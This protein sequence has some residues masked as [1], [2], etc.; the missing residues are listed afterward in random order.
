MKG[1]TLGKNTGHIS[2]VEEPSVIGSLYKDMRNHNG[3]KPYECNNLVKASI[4]PIMLKYMRELTLERNH[5]NA[6]NVG[7]PSVTTVH[8]ESMK[9][10]TVERNLLNV[11]KVRK[12]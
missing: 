8:F 5:L 6:R 10:F 4:V 11:S 12:P 1:L 3:E 9:E 2:N 7:K